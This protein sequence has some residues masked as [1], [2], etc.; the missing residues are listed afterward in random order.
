MGFNLDLRCTQTQVLQRYKWE[1]SSQKKEYEWKGIEYKVHLIR[2]WGVDQE[3]QVNNQ[4]PEATSIL[5]SNYGCAVG[6][7]TRVYHLCAFL[8]PELVP[9]ISIRLLKGH[10]SS[11]RTYH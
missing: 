3:Y 7:K 9:L 4:K 10:D 6:L 1:N 11:N 5:P 8:E 2:T